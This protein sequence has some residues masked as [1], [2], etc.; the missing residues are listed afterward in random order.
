MTLRPGLIDFLYKLRWD[1]EKVFGPL[2]NNLGEQ[3]AWA[4][5]P[6]A[7]TIQAR[8]I[9]LVHNLLLLVEMRLKE[10]GIEN[11][12]ELARKAKELA[13]TVEIATKAGRKIPGPV[14]AIQRHT[15][16]SVK[17]LRWLRSSLLDRLAWQAAT[18]RLEA[19]YAGL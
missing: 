16:R 9:C 8:L 15:Q 1:I 14:L 5:T 18:P 7:K 2:K 13:I 3:Q 11:E 17:L 10:D 19:L 12:A 4:S 6:T